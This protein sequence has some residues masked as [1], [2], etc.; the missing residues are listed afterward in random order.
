MPD[1]L[2]Q[3]LVDQRL[4]RVERLARDG[5]QRHEWLLEALAVRRARRMSGGRR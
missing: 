4:D 5:A 3:T 1:F 2:T